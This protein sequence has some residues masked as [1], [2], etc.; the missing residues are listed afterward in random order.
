MV[1]WWSGGTKVGAAGAIVIV[2]EKET[3]MNRMDRI[4]DMGINH[5]GHREHILLCQRLR[6]DREGRGAACGGVFR[7]Q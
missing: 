3:W 4:W 2:I 1:E 6:R 5:R 7:V